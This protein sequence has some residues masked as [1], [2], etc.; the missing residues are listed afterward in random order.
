[1]YNFSG[2]LHKFPNVALIIKERIM[3]STVYVRA[4]TRLRYLQIEHVRAHFR[5]FP[6]R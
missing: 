6:N 4:Y 1:M 2:T 3:T 5:R